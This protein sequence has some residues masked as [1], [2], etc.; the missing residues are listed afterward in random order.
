MGR[1]PHWWSYC[2]QTIIRPEE[3]GWQERAQ[4]SLVFSPVEIPSGS[5]RT[6]LRAVAAA[7]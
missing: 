5:L 7:T 1:E 3:A 4:L 6:S 2:V